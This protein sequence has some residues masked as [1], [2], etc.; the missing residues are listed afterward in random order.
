[1]VNVDNC[2][3][4]GICVGA[5]PTSTP[6]RRATEIVPGIELPAHPVSDL[7]ERSIAAASRF[8]GNARV[9]VYACE[10]A[11]AESVQAPGVAVISMPCVAMLPPAFIDFALSRN[12]ADGVMLAGCAEGDCYYRLGNDWSQRRID[13][14]RDPYLRNRVPR[15]RVVTSWMRSGNG[16]RQQ[17]LGDF[18]AQLQHLPA[19]VRKRR[20]ERE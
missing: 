12:L 15:E 7:R 3:S 18:I 14:E 13:G 1:V 20:V 10:H 4:C 8:N 9:L 16:G 11:G 17:Q 6:F 19:M 5:C 2:V